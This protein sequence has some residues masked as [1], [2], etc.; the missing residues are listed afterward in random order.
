MAIHTNQWSPD[1]CGCTIEFQWDDANDQVHIPTQ[2]VKDCPEHIGLVTP[3]SMH[4]TLLKENRG[5]NGIWNR[6]H[7]VTEFPD[8]A[9]LDNEGRVVLK[10]GVTITWFFTGQ[11][12]TRVL[13]VDLTGTPLTAQQKT[14]VQNW[15]DANILDITIVII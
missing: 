2:I 15:V 13:N 9:E 8:L 3:E 6:L 10:N 1:T 14:L 12:D 5:K 4:T 11:D 7:N